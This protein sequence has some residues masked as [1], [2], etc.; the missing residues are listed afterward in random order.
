VARVRAGAN[1]ADSGDGETDLWEVF[2]FAEATLVAPGLWDLRLRLR[3]Q[4]G[5]DGVMPQ[6]WPAGSRF[7]L[8]NGAVAQWDFLP[9]QREMERHYR[10]GPAGRPPSDPAWG[11]RAAAF[12]GIGLRPYAVAHPRLRPGPGGLVLTWIRRTRL[13][14]DSWTPAEVPLGEDREAYLV[15]VARGGTLLR[16]AEVAQPAWT[17]GAAQ[18]AADGPGPVVL[19]VAQLSDRFGPGPFRSV[20]TAIREGAP[21]ALT[22]A[23]APY[24]G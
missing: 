7:V 3:G 9:A 15:R 14:G 20:E 10:W 18:Q 2:Q 8:L 23:P 22:V 24:L 16:E 6:D 4:A 13:D 21:G 19:S 1:R 11:H 5:T 12:R 17:Y